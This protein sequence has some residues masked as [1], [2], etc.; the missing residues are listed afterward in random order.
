[1]TTR[2]LAAGLVFVLS[3]IV[4]SAAYGNNLDV[5]AQAR[6]LEGK[7]LVERNC[8][9]CYPRTREQLERGISRLLEALQLGYPRKADVYKLLAEGY[10]TL[11]AVDAKPDSEE[12]RAFIDRRNKILEDLVAIS[13]DDPE[14][15]FMY[16]GSLPNLDER[17]VVLRKILAR[18]PN[19][20]DARYAIGMALIAK[21]QRD[22]GIE[23][24]K[25][26]VALASGVRLRTY[27]Y[28]LVTALRESGR[29]EE[30]RQVMRRIEHENGK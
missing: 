18:D 21:G 27:G 17:L 4:I 8:G 7:Q 28:A 11:A 26:A 15:L 2:L 23:E 5:S 24:L 25:K 1:M 29:H 30:A 20:V 16:A 9:E 6:F 22:M 12:R 13:P 14:A 19:H 3:S 10:N